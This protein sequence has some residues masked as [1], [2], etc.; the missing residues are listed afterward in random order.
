MKDSDKSVQELRNIS[1]KTQNSDNLDIEIDKIREDTKDEK[2]INKDELTAE[3]F[4]ELTDKEKKKI[5]EIVD[6][7][8]TGTISTGV[9]SY[10]D[11]DSVEDLIK[12]AD[13]ALYF[14]KASGR[15]NVKNTQDLEVDIKNTFLKTQDALKE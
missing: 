7:Y 10:K 2:L 6:Y 14:A 9:E 13:K 12:Q 5:H 1:K 4:A 11:H 3:T 15:N 8:L